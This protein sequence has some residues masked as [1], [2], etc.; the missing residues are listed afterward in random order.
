MFQQF[1]DYHGFLVGYLYADPKDSKDK[2]GKRVVVLDVAYGSTRDEYSKRR[3]ILR[4][5]CVIFDEYTSYARTL[6]KGDCVIA[7]GDRRP[8]PPRGFKMNPMMVGKKHF[9]FIGGTGITR[10]WKTEAE[11]F[12]KNQIVHELKQAK[13]QTK[14]QSN[15]ESDKF[16]EIKSDLY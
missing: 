12:T 16:T 4:M 9:G 14:K 7:F 11:A 6:K 2:T 15:T 1:D 8:E 13:R 5:P 10:A 3:T